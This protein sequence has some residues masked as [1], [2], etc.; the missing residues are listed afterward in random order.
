MLPIGETPSETFLPSASNKGGKGILLSEELYNELPILVDKHTTYESLRVVSVRLDPCFKKKVEDEL[1]CEPQIRL[2]LQ[3]LFES[4]A[5]F[6][7][8][9][10]YFTSA[11]YHIF[12]KVSEEEI[13][14]VIRDLREVASKFEVSFSN[15]RLITHELLANFNSSSDRDKSFR[16]EFYQKLFQAIGLENLNRVTYMLMENRE[17]G[18]MFYIGKKWL[19]GGVDIEKGKISA[20]MQIPGV[21]FADNSVEDLKEKTQVLDHD[22]D[23]NQ[24]LVNDTEL[25]GSLKDYV[26]AFSLPL[27][28]A[29]TQEKPKELFEVVERIQDPAATGPE[30]NMDCLSCHASFSLY[31]SMLKTKADNLVLKTPTDYPE[32]YSF[33]LSVGESV[34]HGFSYFDY[35]PAISPR[36]IYETQEVQ[37]YLESTYAL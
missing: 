25:E 14:K 27:D 12:Y 8:G 13:V 9:K 7:K 34:L 21:H 30:T 5:S 3:S 1:I 26:K 33:I 32:P 35:H 22:E 4:Q 29:W 18:P 17:D 36:V 28:M 11:A 15:N 24:V 20:L 2:V 37:S 6:S 23:R 10:A 16:E 19:W 31:S